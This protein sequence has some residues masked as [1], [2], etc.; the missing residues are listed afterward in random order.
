[1]P[2]ILAVLVYLVAMGVPIFLLQHFHALHWLWP[3]PPPG[4]AT[5][6]TR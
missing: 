2:A 5:V 6:R 4:L 3:R 1:M